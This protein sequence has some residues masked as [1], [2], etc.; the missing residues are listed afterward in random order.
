MIVA[1]LLVAV[2][3][4]GAFRVLRQPPAPAPASGG[5][6]VVFEGSNSSTYAH[7]S[8]EFVLQF[9]LRNK[10]S[11]LVHVRA[12][13]AVRDPGFARFATAVLPGFATGSA[14]GYDEVAAAG[15]KV[16]PLD[17]GSVAQLTLA[18]RVVCD[19]APAVRAGIEV[20]VDERTVEVALP[21]I[22][23]EPWS[24]AVTKAFCP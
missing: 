9:D 23:G 22:D 11:A 7:D 8:K 5:Q 12:A 15:G 19:P 17:P 10:G 24:V 3:V 1:V 18:G 20:R 13:T 4:V 6:T 2:L 21:D 14:P 16:V